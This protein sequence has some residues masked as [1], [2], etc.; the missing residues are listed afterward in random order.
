MQL[1]LKVLK[2]SDL[3]IKAFEEATS[4]WIEMT[5]ASS[6]KLTSLET[7]VIQQAAVNI[8]SLQNNT[9]R[10]LKESDFTPAVQLKFSVSATYIGTDNGFSLFDEYNPKFQDENSAW[11]QRLASENSVFEPL[12][13]PITSSAVSS[14]QDSTTG[15]TGMAPMGMATLSLVAV[16]AV[17][18]GVIASIYS[19]RNYKMAAYGEELR[20]PV[21]SSDDADDNND[22]LH[23][24][25]TGTMDVD[26]RQGKI[27]V[28]IKSLEKK[29]NESQRI[30][31]MQKNSPMSPN[32][33]E[34]GMD[35]ESYNHAVMMNT[36]PNPYAS[37]NNNN[38]YPHNIQHLQNSY[39][40]ESRHYAQ[41]PP[42]AES[43]A[44][45]SPRQ[46]PQTSLF[47]NQVRIEQKLGNLQ[48]FL[49]CY[50][51]NFL[52]RQVSLFKNIILIWF[53]F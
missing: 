4:A 30:K 37:Q 3:Q 41:D 7:N 11:I 27:R 36:H 35:Q 51:N 21:Q 22:T 42:S 20:S 28:A 9:A 2:L 13:P 39:P 31:Y 50:C 8:T 29:S 26:E 16:G 38:V 34:R 25:H 48:S 53:L 24:L 43:E 10:N 47:D 32:T 19:V 1:E 12:Q 23:S 49:R 14:G 44:N 15:S 6:G 46:D 5:D 18:L 45:F 17:V 40:V 52:K 33:L